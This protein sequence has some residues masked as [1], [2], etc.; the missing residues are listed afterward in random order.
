MD[1]KIAHMGSR[2]ALLGEHP[3]D[4]RLRLFSNELQV[5]DK[6]PPTLLLQ[7]TDDHLVD[8]ENSVVFF[9]ALRQHDVPVEMMIFEKGEHGFF[10]LPR[11]EWHG[12]VFGWLARKGWLKP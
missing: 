4:E 12:R 2:T 3:A 7:A 8:V 10:L 11:D 9:E 5:T 1:S 6:T